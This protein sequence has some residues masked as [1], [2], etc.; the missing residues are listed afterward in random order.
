MLSRS[1]STRTTTPIARAS[2]WIV[3]SPSTPRRY[4]VERDLDW[5]R[6]RRLSF[7]RD[8]SVNDTLQRAAFEIARGKLAARAYV[9]E[10]ARRVAHV[11]LDDCAANLA[12]SIGS[13][14]RTFNR[15]E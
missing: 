5:Q 12:T 7:C 2:P 8:A 3:V 14:E 4:L 9:D 15:I 6:Y 11:T 10:T 13:W 1:P